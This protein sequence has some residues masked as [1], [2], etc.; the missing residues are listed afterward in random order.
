M[1]ID[2]IA[3]VTPREARRCVERCITAGVVPFTTSSPGM[4][5]SSI[6]RQIAEDYGM[7]L[8]DHRL[9]TSAP[10]DLSGLPRFTKDGRAE[11][12]PFADLFPLE[13]DKV[14]DGYNGW[15]LFLD[16]FNSASKSVQAAAYKL[17][18]DHMTGQKKLHERVAIVCAGNK[19]T[20]RAI[21]NAL[22]TAMQ[23][24]VVHIEMEVSFDEWLEDVALP[25]KWDERIIAYLSANRTKLMDFDPEHNE[26]TFCCPRT[27]EFVNK[28]LK[29]TSG[30]IPPE[31]TVLYAGTITSG[32]ATSFVQFTN[33]YR[34][35]I[36][37]REIVKDPENAR[38][39]NKQDLAWAVVTSLTTQTDMSNYREVFKYVNRMEMTFQ[40]LFYR[41][42][43]KSLPQLNTTPE[44]RDAAIKLGRYVYS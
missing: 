7:I 14:P 30:P 39:P 3:V 15:I 31:D 35:M 24:R 6:V 2:S 11:F 32:V 43:G 13:G 22:S 25:Q 23:S 27:W 33:V 18:L 1:S 40:I 21:V 34:E 41:A 8:I 26:K 12:A 9:S 17:I 29:G 42:I 37:V 19:A 16:E 5:K 38:L 10:E 28:L 36:T 44:W 20:D 4:G